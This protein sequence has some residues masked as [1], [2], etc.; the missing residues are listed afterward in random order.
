MDMAGDEGEGEMY[1]ESNLH[2]HMK[3]RYQF[4]IRCVVQG[5]LTGACNNLEG[6]KGEGDGR[7]LQWEGTYVY[8][9]LIHVDIWQKT[10]KFCK[11][12]ILQLKTRFFFFKMYSLKTYPGTSLAVQWLKLCLPV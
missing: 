6:C 10:T 4:G 11:E 5:T 8:L 12:I 9:Y 3:N 7:E 1:G 2:Y